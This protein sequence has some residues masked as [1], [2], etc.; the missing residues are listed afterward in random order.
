MSL[1]RAG[2]NLVVPEE[3]PRPAPV[4]VDIS[5]LSMSAAST[6]VLKDE[7]RRQVTPVVVD[8]SGI[9]M[10]EVGA[11]LD[12]LREE[13]TLVNPDISHIRLAD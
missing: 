4:K 13:K 9:S 3:L 8:L 2:G 11:P 6:D 12:E 1:A 10:A 7:E 5:G